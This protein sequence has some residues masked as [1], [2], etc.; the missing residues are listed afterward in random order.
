MEAQQSETILIQQLCEGNEHAYKEVYRLHYAVLCAYARQFVNDDFED[1]SIVDDVILHLWEIRQQLRIDRSLRSYLISCVHNRCMNVIRERKV[2][3]AIVGLPKDELLHEPSTAY[4]LST[5]L[6]K[7]LE[8]KIK[9]AVDS[10]PDECRR[11]FTLSRYE[12][13]TYE[14]ISKE[15]GISVNTVKYHIKR[16]LKIL[17]NR[18]EPYLFILLIFGKHF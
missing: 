6:E 8:K 10:L 13:M 12:G 4:P 18:L 7:K 1:E 2:V 3:P 5:L 11:V 17:Y 16:A 14:G 9:Q 15:L